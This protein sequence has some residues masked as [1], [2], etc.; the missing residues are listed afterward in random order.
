VP[1]FDDGVY[2]FPLH[3][4][5]ATVSYRRDLLADAG[6][7]P[8]GLN[9]ADEPPTWRRFAEVVVDARETTGSRFGHTFQAA[10][11]RGLGCCT[12]AEALR[13]W[14]G[15][16]F[17]GS[18]FGPVGGRPVTVAEERV[19][20]ALR[21]LRAFLAGPDADGAN[22][23]YPRLA[24]EA[25]LGWS[26]EPSRK[27]FTEGRAVSH[28]NWPYA[29]SLGIEAFGDDLGVAQLPYAVGDRRA[30]YPDVGGS[31]PAATAEY[32]VVNPY[33][34][35]EAQAAAG[36]V[37][38]AVGSDR[39]RLFALRT[40]D[41][42]PPRPD[43]YGREAAR[44]AVSFGRHLDTLR[45][46][47]ERARAPPATPVWP[48]Q[49]TAVAEHVHGVLVGDRRPATALTALRDALVE[50]ESEGPGQE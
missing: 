7:D 3:V 46:A 22:P 19:V 20:D 49:R 29:L 47:A 2:G 8:D 38:R 39:F 42:L 33:A 44:S 41:W 36:R 14:G 18:P 5:P 9:W 16:Y 31:R 15:A 6:Y 45:D 28:R 50:I 32:A 17:G 34:P 43:L 48:R 30:S 23:D 21:M 1:R 4:R 40:F 27:P 25:A 12:F 11:Y 24:P 13:S 10:R 37:L 35:A 26:E